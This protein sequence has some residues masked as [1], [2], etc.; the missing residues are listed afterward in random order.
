[1]SPYD[2]LVPHF[3]ARYDVNNQEFS[4]SGVVRPQTID[5]LAPSIALLKDLISRVRGVLYV[6]IKRLTQM[7]NTAFHAFSRVIIDACRAYPDLKFVVV[8]SSVVGW[9]TQKFRRLSGIEPQHHR[10][11]VRQ[12]VLSGPEFSGRR[13]IHPDPSHTDEDDLAP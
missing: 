13:R 10:R 5:E 11:G 9:T 4:I 1:M 12:R 2:P 6:N 7:N 3:K 8:T